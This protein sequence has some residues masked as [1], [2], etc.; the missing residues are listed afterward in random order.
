MR[1][2]SEAWNTGIAESHGEVVGI[3]S[4]HAELAPDYVSKAIDVLHRTQAD[5]VGGPV[6]AQSEGVIGKIIAVAMST[7]FGVGSAN[8]RYTDQEQ[9]TDT[10]FMGLCKRSTYVKLGGIGYRNGSQPG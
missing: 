2:Q 8:F 5:M 1:I 10:V 4:A 7:P 3:I 9:E 6:H